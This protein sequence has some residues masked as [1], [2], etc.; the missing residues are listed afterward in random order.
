MAAPLSSYLETRRAQI[1]QAVTTGH[2]TGVS[3]TVSQER[4]T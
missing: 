2:Y 3:H 1:F 4:S